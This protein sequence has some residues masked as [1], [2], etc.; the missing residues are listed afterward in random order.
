MRSALAIVIALLVALFLAFLLGYTVLALGGGRNWGALWGSQPREV[1]RSSEP[2]RPGDAGGLASDELARPGETRSGRV[3]VHP[4]D[5]TAELRRRIRE[6]EAE[7]EEL[8][9]RLVSADPDALLETP[10]AIRAALRELDPDDMTAVRKRN[11]RRAELLELFLERFPGDPGA[12]EMLDELSGLQ[13]GWLSDPQKSLEVLDRFAERVDLP[14][15]KR[16]GLYANVLHF[17]DRLQE[18]DQSYQRVIYSTEAPA[19]E[20]WRARFFCA[21]MY[22]RQGMY[23]EARARFEELLLLAGENPP[24]GIADTVEGAK[25]QLRLIEQYTQPR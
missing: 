2:G 11:Q 14:A 15:W 23:D 7:I 25:T 3:A 1:E 19:H 4:V 5:E 8:K 20:R 13:L 17:N 6:L 16:D 21:Y 12:G 10:D 24:P 22:M 18:A 9:E